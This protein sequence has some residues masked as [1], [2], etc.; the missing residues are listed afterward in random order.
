MVLAQFI[1]TTGTNGASGSWYGINI[2]GPCNARLVHYVFQH[3]NTH[4]IQL[5][6][7]IFRLGYSASSTLVQTNAGVSIAVNPGAGVLLTNGATFAFDQSHQ[8]MH[9]ENVVIPGR[10]FWN[11]IDVTTGLVLTGNWTIVL[12]FDIEELP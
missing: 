7:D 8:K 10:V 6:S 11:V 4:L 9:W 3:N 5:Q 12:S 2:N 1:I